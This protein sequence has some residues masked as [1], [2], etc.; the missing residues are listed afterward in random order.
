MTTSVIG[1]DNCKNYGVEE[2]GNRVFKG[3]H[4]LKRIDIPNSVVRFGENIFEDTTATVICSADSPIGKYCQEHGIPMKDEAGE[5]LNEGRSL[6]KSG[7][8]YDLMRA[9]DLFRDAAA[10]GNLDAMSASKAYAPS[11]LNEQCILVFD[12]TLFGSADERFLVTNKR[13]YIKESFR[14]P[15]HYELSDIES[16]DIDARGRELIINDRE[17]FTLIGYEQK[18]GRLLCNLLKNIVSRMTR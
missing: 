4:N 5:K 18:D 2:L 16:I 6:L 1:R 11:A 17:A 14:D 10:L 3:C 12:S 15:F 9:Y 7:N 8:D 13:F